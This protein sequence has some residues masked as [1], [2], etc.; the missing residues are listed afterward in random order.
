MSASTR[1][2]RWTRLLLGLFGVVS[3]TLGVIAVFRTENGTGSG[4]LIAFGGIL[5]VLMLLWE[6]IDSLEMGGTKLKLHAAAAERY[7]KAEHSEALGRHY[8]AQEIRAEAQSMM[9]AAG[10]LAA[11]Y[12]HIRSSMAEGPERTEAM[13]VIAHRMHQVAAKE[14]L[15]RGEVVR[16][17]AEGND[18]QRISAIAVM[19]VRPDLRDVDTVRVALE[20]PRSR[21]EQYHGLLVLASALGDM[22]SAARADLRVFLDNY[23]S[24]IGPETQRKQILEEMR[25]Q[26]NRDDPHEGERE[27]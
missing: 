17:L 15:D 13:K 7:A 26:L 24:R 18:E 8:E 22:D 2:P 3:F 12:R 21:F 27:E 6:R 9:R 16:W 10:A 19:Q 1:V 5:L 20:E 11:R 25:W 4:V 14:A 23:E